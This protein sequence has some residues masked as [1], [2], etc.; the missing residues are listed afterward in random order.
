MSNARELALLEKWTSSSSNGA[1][2][3]PPLSSPT[4]P[5]ATKFCCCPNRRRYNLKQ[6]KLTTTLHVRNIFVDNDFNFIDDTNENDNDEEQSK[7]YEEQDILNLDS[8]KNYKRAESWPSARK[9]TRPKNATPSEVEEVHNRDNR[10]RKNKVTANNNNDDADDHDY[11]D[12]IECSSEQQRSVIEEN[13]KDKEK[14]RVETRKEWRRHDKSCHNNRNNCLPNQQREQQP[15]QHERK[16]N[17]SQSRCSIESVIAH[18]DDDN[19]ERHHQQQQQQPQQQLLQQLETLLQQTS[20]NEVSE[21]TATTTTTDPH[22]TLDC[23]NEKCCENPQNTLANLDDQIAAATATIT[24]NTSPLIQ[25]LSEL[26]EFNRKETFSN[27]QQTTA[28]AIPTTTTA[29]AVT[30]RAKHQHCNNCQFCFNQS[31]RNFSQLQKSL[32]DNDNNDSCNTNRRQ[33]QK[34]ATST[35]SDNRKMTITTATNVAN[36]FKHSIAN[37]TAATASTATTTATAISN[38]VAPN[39]CGLSVTMAASNSITTSPTWTP[40]SRT[41]PTTLLLTST[42]ATPTAGKM[43]TT[44]SSVPINITLPTSP[45]LPPVPPPRSY[46]PSS[47]LTTTVI[48]TTMVKRSPAN[49][50]TT[51]T[52]TT[53]TSPSA[54][55]ASLTLEKSLAF[56]TATAGSNN[57]Q[58]AVGSSTKGDKPTTN[59]CLIDATASA[60]PLSVKER[61]AALVAG[62]GKFLVCNQPLFSLPAVKND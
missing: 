6:P 42:T 56:I 34:S 22:K 52:T 4:S 8:N 33:Q 10:N 23:K 2:I 3:I 41:V 19:K 9:T 45:V 50:S 1:K 37:N 27:K 53:A 43:P 39:N 48:K 49:E 29:A 58:D 51:P 5:K 16:S 13:D 60:A 59:K 32:Q 18:K 47:P 25:R 40:T 62:N 31:C 15:Q 26:S 44:A 14:E 20:G 35:S 12:I 17:N 57:V 46:T 61:I 36:N 54:T 55:S 30:L 28:T 24:T 21:A 38:T 7:N 11:D